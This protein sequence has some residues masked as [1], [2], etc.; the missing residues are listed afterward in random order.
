MRQDGVGNTF[1]RHR[2]MDRQG[3]RQDH[4]RMSACMQA[5]THLHTCM[6]ACLDT[7]M[8]AHKTHRGTQTNAILR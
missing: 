5:H 6:H 7:L 1:H 2:L 4:R 8:H 3:L